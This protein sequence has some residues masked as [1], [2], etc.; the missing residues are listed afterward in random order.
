MLLIAQLCCKIEM[1]K[2]ADTEM[3]STALHRAR[4]R[5]LNNGCATVMA[6]C[7]SATRHRLIITRNLIVDKQPD[8]LVMPENPSI[9]L[10]GAIPGPF[11]V[12]LG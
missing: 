5:E 3:L 11:G 7:A 1:F 9:F 2:S 4:C 8:G 6:M 10:V 12:Y